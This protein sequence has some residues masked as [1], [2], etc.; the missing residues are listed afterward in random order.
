MARL[1]NNFELESMNLT[2]LWNHSISI[3]RP[4]GYPQVGEKMYRLYPT[5]YADVNGRKFVALPQNV[6][7]RDPEIIKKYN[8]DI[9]S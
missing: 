7:P 5:G 6:N 1:Y 3:E 4:V 9:V 8:L 2:Q